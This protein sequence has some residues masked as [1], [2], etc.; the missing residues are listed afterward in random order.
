MKTIYTLVK[1]TPDLSPIWP[2]L[3]KHSPSEKSHCKNFEA[4]RNEENESQIQKSEFMLR[5]V[6][7]TINA[8]IEQQVRSRTCI[9]LK[10]DL[11]AFYEQILISNEENYKAAQHRQN[12]REM[13][14]VY[15]D[16]ANSHSIE[17]R[18]LEIFDKPNIRQ[19]Y[20][21]VKKL[22]DQ[23]NYLPGEDQQ[24]VK[25]IKDALQMDLVYLRK[26]DMDEKQIRR[27]K[28]QA[29]KDAVGDMSNAKV[30]AH[31]IQS[32]S[33]EKGDYTPE[34]LKLMKTADVIRRFIPQNDESDFFDDY[35]YYL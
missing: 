13:R 11:K 26:L 21:V 27:R 30:L 24:K 29:L 12:T 14:N 22:L 5:Q 28:R 8:I 33:K 19:K 32:F 7:E 9:P 23:Y 6:M 34:F 17:K 1:T 31:Q 25:D 20:S 35:F 18:S 4:I 10:G 3:S 2:G 15:L 16:E